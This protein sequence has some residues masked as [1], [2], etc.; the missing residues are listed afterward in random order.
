MKQNY[1]SAGYFDE[2]Q[3]L[4]KK[5][6]RKGVSTTAGRFYGN[7]NGRSALQ[8]MWCWRGFHRCSINFGGKVWTFTHTDLNNLPFEMWVIKALGQFNHKSGS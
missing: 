7:S 1:A 3:R 8:H 6:L 5:N 2:E 4:S